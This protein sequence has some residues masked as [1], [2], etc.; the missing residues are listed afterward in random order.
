MGASR[1]TKR[2]RAAEHRDKME[3][4]KLKNEQNHKDVARRMQEFPLAN[5]SQHSEHYG[6]TPA[7]QTKRMLEKSS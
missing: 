2:E 1:N 6:E 3:M 5:Q 7:E 4:K